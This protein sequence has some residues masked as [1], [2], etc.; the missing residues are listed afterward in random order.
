MCVCTLM[1]VLE[2]DTDISFPSQSV[3]VLTH[4]SLS[5]SL[6]SHSQS[7]GSKY[8]G[9]SGVEGKSYNVFSFPTVSMFFFSFAKNTSV[10]LLLRE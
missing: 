1:C 7:F 8:G 9:G 6:G 10:V 2:G 3:V 5:L 4:T